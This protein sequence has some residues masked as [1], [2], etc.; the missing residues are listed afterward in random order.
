[1]VG[2]PGDGAAEDA[3]ALDEAAAALMTVWSHAHNAP[4]VP[5]PA[6][7]LRALLVLEQGPVNV[8]SLAERLGALV[9]SASRL[10]DRLEAAGLLLRDPGRDRREVTVRLTADGQELLDRLRVRRREELAR[11]LASMPASARAAL[12]WGLSQFDEAASRTGPG[13]PFWRLA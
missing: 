1:M 13:G 6:T 10:C 8:S 9:S 4:D 2:T 12:L 5:V 11:V 7:Q 3:A